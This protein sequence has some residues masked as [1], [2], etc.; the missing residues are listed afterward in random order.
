M[1]GDVEKAL[2]DIVAEHSRRDAEAARHF[3]QEMKKGGSYQTDVY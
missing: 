3:V 2:I 1:A